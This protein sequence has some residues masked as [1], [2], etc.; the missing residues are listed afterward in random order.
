[1]KYI[2]YI[3]L[4]ILIQ[5][6]SQKTEEIKTQVKGDS[7]K[8]Q[9]IEAYNS[10]VVALENGDVLFAA[11]KFN[12]AELF[13]P[14]SE[15]APKAA[16]MASY[17]YWTQGYYSDSINELKRFIKRYP[18]NNDLDY[19]YYLLAI[20][21]Y[22]SII[23]EKKDIRPLNEA[24]K[25]FE[26]ILKNYPKSD[27]A[28]DGKYKLEL[29]QDLLAAK[30][31]YLARHYMKKQKWI[32]AINRLKFVTENYDTTIYIEEALHRLVEVHYKI[33]L[34]MEAQKYAKILGY[35]YQSSDWYKQSYKVFNKN[36]SSITNKKKEKDKK[37]LLDKIKS[38]F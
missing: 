14:Q 17:A 9:M 15:W 11:K 18:K 1:M 8:Q 7:L 30:E 23:D 38:F 32:A 12:E 36:Y 37:D 34:E 22:D 10:G 26:F 24:K 19:A 5:A 25:Y 31:M 6:C 28:L 20:N 16:L 2:I 21:Y 35:N 3:T 13:F 33:G 4:F 29:I 27:Y